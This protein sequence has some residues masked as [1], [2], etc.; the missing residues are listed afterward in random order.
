[1]TKPWHPA[2]AP[3]LTIPVKSRARSIET[4]G[5][6]GDRATGTVKSSYVP[7][8]I[9]VDEASDSEAFVINVGGI[10]GIKSCILPCRGFSHGSCSLAC[11]TEM[12]TLKRLIAARGMGLFLHTPVS[13]WTLRLG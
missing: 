9:G 7:I 1:M 3:L 5:G 6:E 11:C 10:G 2:A 8:A 13:T 4:V 12:A